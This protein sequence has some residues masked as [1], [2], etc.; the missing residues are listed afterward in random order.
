MTN[1]YRPTIRPASMVTLPSGVKWE[2]SQAP[3]DIAHIRTDIP[4]CDSR[5]GLIVT[6]RQLTTEECEQ[7]SLKY[8]RFA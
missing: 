8:E 7:F 2:F 3:W 4:R 6:D 5:Y 1:T